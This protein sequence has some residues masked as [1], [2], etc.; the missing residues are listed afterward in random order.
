MLT[1]RVGQEINRNEVLSKLVDMMYERNNV[2]L[3]RGTF[4]A[5]GD[6]IEV[7]PANEK[8]YGIRI[9][10]FGDEVDRI[11]EFDVLTGAVVSD[12]KF[13]SILPASHFVTSE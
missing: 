11:T 10:L 9:E 8:S 4:R 6:V 7:I 13:I 2:D 5:K 3:V 12:K 1:L